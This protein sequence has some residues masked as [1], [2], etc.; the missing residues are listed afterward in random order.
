VDSFV[1]ERVRDGLEWIRRVR[2]EEA[3]GWTLYPPS[4]PELRPN[5]S[6][7]QDGNWGPVKQEIA[8]KQEEITLLWRCGPK[9]RK[10]ANENGV[11]SWKEC[12]S[13]VVDF[14]NEDTA[15][16]LDETIST[17]LSNRPKK[18][19][20]SE[21]GK[22]LLKKHPVEIYLD[23][24]TLSI[25]PPFDCIPYIVKD[26]TPYVF[27]IGYGIVKD[28]VWSY[29][30]YLAEGIT[31]EEERENMEKFVRDLKELGDYKLYCWGT[32][33]KNHFIRIMGEDTFPCVD[34][35]NLF[36]K[37][38]ITVKGVFDF[39]LKNIAKGMY[40]NGQI[41][42]TWEDGMSGLNAMIKGRECYK[43]LAG[44]GLKMSQM[45]FPIMEEII[46]YNEMDC[47]TMWEIVEYLRN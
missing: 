38:P 27:Q 1:K 31:R 16:T 11:N 39:S 36:R 5:M 21:R 13:T 10:I 43:I 44:N 9:R 19:K 34:L 37:E 35:L 17:N 18:P 45:K 4:V 41:K 33:E 25:D 30:T 29:K 47:K 6:N 14:K 40:K 46:K 22:E 20:L 28:G 42:S 7:I 8:T 32:T 26:T 23:Y 12:D 15:R 3:K 24:E 2:S